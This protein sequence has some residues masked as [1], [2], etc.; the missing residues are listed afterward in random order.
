M[1]IHII[2]RNGGKNQL[3]ELDVFRLVQRLGNLYLRA[4]NVCSYNSLEVWCK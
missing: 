2:Q 4:A 1:V 3:L